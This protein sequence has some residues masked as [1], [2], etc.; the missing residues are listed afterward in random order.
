M[1]TPYSVIFER[2]L[3]KI[4]DYDLQSL[5]QPLIEGQML[6]F[7]KSAIPNFLYSKNDLED[8]DD[9][10]Q[11]FNFDLNTLE[12][13]ILSKLMVAEWI[14]PEILRHENLKQNLGNRDYQIFSPANHL[15]KLIE[16]R[17]E[18]RSEVNDV[19][20]FYYYDT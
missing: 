18:I 13:E 20:N 16:L 3:I 11:V 10:L 15:E 1:Q 19:L 5:S 12:Q 2:F 4:R 6:R 8:R 14:S 9:T 7:M 17:K